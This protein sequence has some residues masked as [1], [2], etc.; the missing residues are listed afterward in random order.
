MCERSA[1]WNL[2]KPV[3]EMCITRYVCVTQRILRKKLS[4]KPK[5]NNSGV[6][7]NFIT[8]EYHDS[9]E[10]KILQYEDDCVR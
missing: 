7:Y 9:K 1:T 8:F 4:D 6:N 2:V 10:G 3:C 5:K